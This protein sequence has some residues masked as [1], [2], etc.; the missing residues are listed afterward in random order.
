MEFTN[1]HSY[2]VL[3]G[4]IKKC[5]NNVG[6]I[7][8]VS[9]FLDQRIGFRRLY[10]NRLQVGAIIAPQLLTFLASLPLTKILC[11]EKDLGP[12]LSP[13]SFISPEFIEDR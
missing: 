1:I 6:K 5:D 10:K 13:R 2:Y 12:H 7:G 9:I 4:L 11:F 3:V 8:I